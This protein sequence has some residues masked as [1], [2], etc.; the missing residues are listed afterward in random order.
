MKKNIGIILLT[1][2]ILAL[3]CFPANAAETIKSSKSIDNVLGTI[4][5]PALLQ[6]GV[7]IYSEPY[8][9]AS[10]YYKIILEDNGILSISSK[11]MGDEIG[12]ANISLCDS[13]MK[14][15]SKKQPYGKFEDLTESLNTKYCV[16]KGTYFIKVKIQHHIKYSLVYTFEKA[17]SNSGTSK[18][19]AKSLKTDGTVYN[20]IF[21]MSDTRTGN[22]YKFTLD[23]TTDLLFTY[24][25]TSPKGMGSYGSELNLA[26]TKDC[27]SYE[28]SSRWFYLH[29]KIKSEP[30]SGKL[31]VRLPKGTYYIWIEN[32]GSPEVN[33]QYSISIKKVSKSTAQ[34]Y[35]E[36][37]ANRWGYEFYVHYDKD[38]YGKMN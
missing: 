28:D 13:S 6:E 27:E 7:K 15:I 34:K 14:E 8:L 33:W 26:K 12:Y 4:N 20:G 24:T 16:K 5:S 31:G 35:A 2:C 18:A 1:I 17:S 25:V 10:Y 19:K 30:S 11:Y 23:K 3:N 36:I 32:Y 22:W 38:I 29:P 37:L 9:R 21:F